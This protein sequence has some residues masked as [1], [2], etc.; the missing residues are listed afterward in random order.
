M[1]AAFDDQEKN[2]K[3]SLRQTEILAKLQS[4]VNDIASDRGESCVLAS[5]VGWTSLYTFHSRPAT[6][7]P[8][9]TQSMAGSCSSPLQ[10]RRTQARSA[11]CCPWR[12][13]CATGEPLRLRRFTF[14]VLN[15]SAA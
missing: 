11:T 3:L 4:I 14:R 13:I 5:L 10:D 1:V 6:P 12:V 8:P 15:P 2:V 7:C 9:S